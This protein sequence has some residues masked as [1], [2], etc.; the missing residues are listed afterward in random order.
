[1]IKNGISWCKGFGTASL[2]FYAMVATIVACAEVKKADKLK[3]KLKESTHNE[4][5]TEKTE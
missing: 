3:K 4:D 2:I 1:M 5:S